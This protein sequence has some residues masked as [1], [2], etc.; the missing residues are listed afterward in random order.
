MTKKTIEKIA[1]MRLKI[2]SNE[3]KAVDALNENIDLEDAINLLSDYRETTEIVKVGKVKT[4]T[5]IGRVYWKETF[6]DDDT[7]ESITL[8]RCKTV[9]INGKPVDYFGNEIQKYETSFDK[10][11]LSKTL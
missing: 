9:R 7:K 6:E 10:N 5:L 1:K 4:P 3:Q 2:N 8:E 11:E